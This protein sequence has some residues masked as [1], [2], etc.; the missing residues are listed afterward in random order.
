MGKA[1]GAL[2]AVLALLSGC[3]R[4]AQYLRE[5]ETVDAQVV[6]FCIRTEPPGATVRIDRLDRAWTTPCDIAD[7][8]ITRGR[9]DVHI[10]LDGYEPANMKVAY[11]GHDPAWIQLRLVSKAKT[12]A[13]MAPSKPAPA[14]VAPAPA[15]APAKPAPPAPEPAP[16]VPAAKAPPVKVEAL[17]GGLRLKV[18]NN[19]AKLRIQAKTV[20]TDPD[21][22]GEYFLPD[23]PPE[24][25]VV[26]FLDPK[27]DMVLQSVEISH[28]GL[29]VP[30]VKPPAPP[31]APKDP[32]PKEAVVVA[33]SDRVGQVKTVSK[34]F[35][36]FVKLEPGLS[37]QPGEEILI[38][39]DGKE[40]ART[41]ILK[42]SKADDIY[43]DGAAQVQ[44]EGAIQKGDEVRRPKQP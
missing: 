11:D 44:K 5:R 1:A 37:I 31:V 39:R 6:A 23:V 38:V 13:W 18:V 2:L 42:I 36:V 26:E 27:T 10:S 34:T 40:V 22:P 9:H 14:V 8:A 3:E 12:P 4:R 24:K 43:P 7:Y 25:V 32:D 41:K 16:E 35:G 29:P 20:V 33:E 30:A 19:A 28:T 15:P 21:K 17:P